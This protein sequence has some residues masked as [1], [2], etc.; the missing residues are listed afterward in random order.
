M[1]AISGPEWDQKIHRGDLI[2]C[3]Y[4]EHNSGVEKIKDSGAE[5]GGKM[6]FLG[7]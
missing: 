6:I 1:N 5:Y 3:Y 7:L 2:F 4:F